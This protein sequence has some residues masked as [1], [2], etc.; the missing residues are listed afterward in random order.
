MEQNFKKFAIEYVQ[1]NVLPMQIYMSDLYTSWWSSYSG[2]NLNPNGEV[3]EIVPYPKK[4][5]V[6]IKDENEQDFKLRFK[7]DEIKELLDQG[8][9]VHKDSEK[10][11]KKLTDIAEW[12]K[13]KSL[14]FNFEILL[15]KRD[16]S[17]KFNENYKEFTLTKDNVIDLSIIR[18][19]GKNCSAKIIFIDQE[20]YMNNIYINI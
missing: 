7:I 3:L 4:A 12:T 15:R 19:Y 5:I 1:N 8:Y 18:L 16:Y 20:G 17:L 9:Q 6:L 14:N 2:L 10:E 13:G 11:Y